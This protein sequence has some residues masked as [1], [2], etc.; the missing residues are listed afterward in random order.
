MN[1]EFF[2][3]SKLVS[4]SI[5]TFF[6]TNY[7]FTIFKGVM[8]SVLLPQNSIQ[9][10]KFMLFVLWRRVISYKGQQ[11]IVS[12]ISL[13]NPGF[14]CS[15]D[16]LHYISQTTH[17]LFELLFIRTALIISV[18]SYNCFFTSF[19]HYTPIINDRTKKLFL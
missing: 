15:V 6:D 10:L 13:N 17:L 3:F 12:V 7:F 8:R 5:L 14:L 11:N 4:S 19:S 2:W 18:D 9:L 16:K 1:T